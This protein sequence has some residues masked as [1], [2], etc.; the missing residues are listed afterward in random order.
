MNTIY[1][2]QKGTNNLTKESI[3]NM[4]MNTIE[5]ENIEETEEEDSELSD[6]KQTT[7]KQKKKYLKR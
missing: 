1:E 4:L 7:L 2:K 6:G 3:I 5:K